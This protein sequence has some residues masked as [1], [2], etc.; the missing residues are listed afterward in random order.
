VTKPVDD[1]T[2]RIRELGSRGRFRQFDDDDCAWCDAAY[3]FF[4]RMPKLH[5]GDA[6]HLENDRGGRRTVTCQELDPIEMHCEPYVFF[7]VDDD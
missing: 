3:E 5:E 2:M 4:I 1:G 6:V 7:R